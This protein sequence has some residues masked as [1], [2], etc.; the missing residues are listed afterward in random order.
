MEKSSLFLAAVIHKALLILKN[1]ATLDAFGEV[2]VEARQREKQDGENKNPRSAVVSLILAWSKLKLLYEEIT[3]S[4]M[5]EIEDIEIRLASNLCIKLCYRDLINTAVV[6]KY[7][8]K[9]FLNPFIIFQY[10]LTHK[11]NEADQ[12]FVTALTGIKKALN[13]IL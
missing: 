11:I 8:L 2:A 13:A 1:E 10:P 6:P 3:H 7:Y 5:P 4:R 12:M 9:A